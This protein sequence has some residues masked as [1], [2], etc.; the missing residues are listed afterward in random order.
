MKAA[1]I[2]SI[3]WLIFAVIASFAVQTPMLWHGEYHF[4]LPNLLIVFVTITSIRNSFEFYSI[5]LHRNKWVRYALFVLNIFLF[6]YILNRLELV[7]GV[8]DSMAMNQLISS[9]SISLNESVELMK[10]IN[11]EFLL[12]SVSS[13][14]GIII[15]NI[16]I[17]TSFWKKAIV[18]REKKLL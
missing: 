8:I 13:F 3:V 7:L 4:L 1:R 12:F 14:I 18:K 15:Y 16:R 9:D 17:L 6:I 10:Y 2:K 5:P 11:N